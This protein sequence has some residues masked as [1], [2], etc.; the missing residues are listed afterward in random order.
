[1]SEIGPSTAFLE[2]ARKNGVY[3]VFPES[4]PGSYLS[5]CL[6][7]GFYE[8]GIPVFANVN[9][10][11]LQEASR[12]WLFPGTSIAPSSGAIIIGDISQ[13][14]LCGP[15][16]TRICEFIITRKERGV[17]VCMGDASNNVSFP[18]ATPCFSVHGVSRIDRGDWRI[19]WSFGLNR[20]VLLKIDFARTATAGQPRKQAFVRNFRPSFNQGVRQAL[21][22][23]FVKKLQR[24]FV[25]DRTLDEGGRFVDAYYAKLARSFGCLAYGGHFMEDVSRHPK[26]SDRGHR[27]RHIIGDEPVIGRW[28]SWRFWESLASGCVTVMLDFDEYGFQL[29]IIPEDGIHYVALRF[30][31]L[32]EVIAQLN[33]DIHQLTQIAE[34]GREWA[35]TYYSPLPTALR[36][37]RIVSE[38]CDL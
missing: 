34:R 36:F 3:F 7:D 24:H 15:E 14:E 28:D 13:F 16:C 6:A 22:L 19:P 32:D 30:D 25:I 21:D 1:M 5:S 17:L 12:Q 38:I 2:H 31:G 4:A 37:L 20:D 11:P 27:V 33:G 8:L 29:P 9:A 18:P 23:A 10:Y 35:I 26:L